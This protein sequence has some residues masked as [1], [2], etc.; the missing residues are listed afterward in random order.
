MNYTPP[1]LGRP[2]E[3]P[4]A[5]LPGLEHVDMRQEADDPGGTLIGDLIAAV[6]RR[7]LG[8]GLWILFCLIAGLGYVA[9]AQPEYVASAQIALEPRVRLPPGTDAA[10]AASAAAPVLDSAQTESQLQ[11]I[12][13]A[14]N[15]RYVFDTLKLDSD[16]AYADKGPGLVGRTLGKIL[17]LFAPPSSRPSDDE[18]ASRAREIA[19]QNFSDRV[20]VRRLG[21]PDGERRVRGVVVRQQARQTRHERLG[22]GIGGAVRRALGALAG[23]LRPDGLRE[24]VGDQP[25]HGVV[26]GSDG[27]PH[28]PRLGAVLERA[29][30][31]VGV[32]RLLVQQREGHHRHDG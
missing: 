18:L 24:P 12:R 22:A 1:S 16:P 21:Q 11:V 25:F 3:L 5:A 32:H 9:V 13:S 28:Q 10:A 4:Q 30:D 23:P 17:G 2:E 20:Q 26:D 6:R 15:L 27:D 7:A 29:E 14:R 31:L 19:F 8:L